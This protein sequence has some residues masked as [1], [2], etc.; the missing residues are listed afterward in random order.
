[1]R[2]DRVGWRWCELLVE[3]GG[4]DVA[5]NSSAFRRLALWLSETSMVLGF[6]IEALMVCSR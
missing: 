1:M 4:V 2:F 3:I 6:D 5:V